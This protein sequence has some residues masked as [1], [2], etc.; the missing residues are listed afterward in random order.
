MGKRSL[1]LAWG[2][3]ATA[4]A[5]QFPISSLWLNE[6]EY[7]LAPRDMFGKSLTLAIANVGDMAKTKQRV[8]IERKVIEFLQQK[9]VAFEAQWKPV[10]IGRDTVVALEANLFSGRNSLEFGTHWPFAK[11]QAERL[12]PAMAG[13]NHDRGAPPP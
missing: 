5:S 9:P 1:A 13:R 12:P 10:H 2:S 6:W 8:T 7:S 11:D 3:A 4:S